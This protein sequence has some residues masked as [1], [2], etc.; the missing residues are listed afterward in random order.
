MDPLVIV[1]DGH[2]AG[3]QS[4]LTYHPSDPWLGNVC[5]AQHTRVKIPVSEA[6]AQ[7]KPAEV[8][9]GMELEEP[10]HSHKGC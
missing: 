5:Q 10:L 7:A 8:S 2:N 9:L 3:V 1:E 4:L 6:I